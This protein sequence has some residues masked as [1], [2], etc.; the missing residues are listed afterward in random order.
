MLPP[1]PLPPYNGS[2]HSRK[3]VFLVEQTCNGGGNLVPTVLRLFGQQL[4]ARRDSGVQEFY[5]RRISA[6]E[7]C[8]LLRG[9]QS[10]KIFFFEFSRVSPAAHPLSKKPEDSGYEI[11]GRGML[12]NK[13]KIICTNNG[14]VNNL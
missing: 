8:K 2:N 4:V 6:V 7:Q 12:T 13:K 14:T 3:T 1:P 9:S 10:K 5:Y 11:A